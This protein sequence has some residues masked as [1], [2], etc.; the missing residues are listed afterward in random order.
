MQVGVEVIVVQLVPSI[1]LLLSLLLLGGVGVVLLLLA[2]VF[3]LKD[4]LRKAGVRVCEEG[5]DLVLGAVD[6]LALGVDRLCSRVHCLLVIALRVAATPARGRDCLAGAGALQLETELVE[7]VAAGRA[8][9][10]ILLVVPLAD[11]AQLLRLPRRCQHPHRVVRRYVLAARHH[12]HHLVGLQTH[13]DDVFQGDPV[14]CGHGRVFYDFDVLSIFYC[15]EELVA[16]LQGQLW[17][18]VD[19]GGGVDHG[20]GGGGAH[21]SGGHA[22]AQLAALF[23]LSWTSELPFVKAELAATAVVHEASLAVIARHL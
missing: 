4:H 8:V 17:S 2:R 5:D 20:L 12:V 19:H 7:V 18:R 6:L 1:G 21:P 3:H 13:L 16:D 11:V 9:E 10:E 14:F 22:H 23:Q 15:R